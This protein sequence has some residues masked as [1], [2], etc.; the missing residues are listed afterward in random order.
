MIRR[1]PAEY[2]IKYL[3]LHPNNYSDEDVEQALHQYHLDFPGG[4]YLVRLRR[5]L[6]RPRPF[7]PYDELHAPSYKFIVQHK[8]LYAFHQD[9]DM[10]A[11]L[12]VLDR[13]KAKEIVETMTITQDPTL[14]I[15]HR[16]ESVGVRLST[17][18]LNRYTHFFW[19]LDLVDSTELR[20]LLEMRFRQTMFEGENA[21]DTAR[22]LAMKRSGY[23]DPRWLAVNAPDAP[24]ASLMN[25]IREGY[26]PS[27]FDVSKLMS[28]TADLAVVRAR[29]ELLS[30]APDS[31]ARARDYSVVAQNMLA[32]L[33]VIGSPTE[34]L[35]KDINQLGI[36]LKH[37][38]NKVKNIS[39]LTDGNFSADVQLMQEDSKHE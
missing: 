17:K 2:Y 21:R 5:Q 29:H 11:A 25:Q 32:L 23:I 20:A 3:L 16:L 38:E 37:A 34:S 7:F 9:D 33:E 14:L 13:P 10:R 22:G 1:S 18:G 31:A 30:G 6:E 8:V 19:N 15:C 36:E 35:F 27:Q 28:S 4:T 24:T 12:K 39:Q 26:L